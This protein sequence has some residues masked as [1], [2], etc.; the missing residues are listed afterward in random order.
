MVKQ[1]IFQ[2]FNAGIFVIG[3]EIA[4]KSSTFTLDD[5]ICS[6]ITVVMITNSFIPNFTL[7]LLN[8]TELVNKVF[9]FFAEK[10]IIVCTQ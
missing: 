5:G 3:S 6:Q 10:S 2:F 8:Y 1:A 9:R 4:A 7:I